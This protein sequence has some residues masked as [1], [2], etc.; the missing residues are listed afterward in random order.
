MP[1]ESFCSVAL[2][3]ALAS[4]KAETEDFRV[5]EACAV[6]RARRG[7]P[8][9]LTAENGGSRHL[10]KHCNEKGRPQERVC[11]PDSSIP[12]ETLKL[13]HKK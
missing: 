13:T 1:L 7:Q 8:D 12:T 2:S 5:L 9:S 10:L 3:L 11:S 6:G 4:T